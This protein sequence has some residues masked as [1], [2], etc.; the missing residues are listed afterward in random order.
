MGK[1]YLYSQKS[2]KEKELSLKNAKKPRKNSVLWVD[3]TKK[4]DFNAIN[5]NFDI[6]PL[7]TDD[8]IKKSS[9]IKAEI[10]EDY[11]F[12]IIHGVKAGKKN[13]GK[14]EE[15]DFIIGKNFIITNHLN[16]KIDAIQHLQ[17]DQKARNT[18]MQKGPEFVM[19]Y[20]I[21]RLIESYFPAIAVIDEEINAIEITIFKNA[22][23][24]SLQKLFKYKKELMTLRKQTSDHREV[25][26]SLTNN[27]I[28]F[29]SSKAEVYYR[30]IYDKIIQLSDAID[31]QKEIISNIAETHTTLISNK[32]NEIMKVLTIIATIMLPLSVIGSI[33]GM[34]FKYMPE[35]YWKWG[36]P[37]VLGFMALIAGSMLYYFRRKKWI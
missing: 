17:E 29:V 33:Y 11:A 26:L 31:S 25:L 4:E 10:F 18:L 19:Q 8:C 5:E 15:I 34:N 24:T 23:Q 9:R 7:T 36:Y 14:I 37:T 32:M 27:K 30:D 3:C 16:T 6:H 21:D 13:R 2:R 35:L 22:D 1:A 20:I 28:S 12:I